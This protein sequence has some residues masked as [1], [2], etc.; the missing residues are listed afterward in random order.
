[1]DKLNANGLYIDKYDNLR[2]LSA[3]ALE[4]SEQITNNFDELTNG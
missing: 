3:E 2:I 4:Q 1:M